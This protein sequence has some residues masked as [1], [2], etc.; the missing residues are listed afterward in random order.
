MSGK[1]IGWAMEQAT[2]SPVT[3]L[4]LLKLADN[5]NEEGVCWPSIALMVTHTELSKRAVREHL[6]RLE[7]LGL[8]RIERR[9]SCGGK[10]PNIYHLLIKPA[11]AGVVQEVHQG[12]GA[13]GAPVV[14][15]AHDLVQEV[16]RGSAGG[17]LPY[18]EEPPSEPSKNLQ[19]RAQARG[20][21]ASGDDRFKPIWQT[22]E[23]WPGFTPGM[24]HRA[25]EQ[26]WKR[27]AEARDYVG[28]AE[29]V[30]AVG[31]H[32]RW[33]ASEN[34]RRARL[35][36]PQPAHLVMHPSRWLRER[37]FDGYLRLA[38]KDAAGTDARARGEADVRESLG[39]EIF[40]RLTKAGFQ[41]QALAHW[42]HGARIEV[43][44][45]ARVVV[46]KDFTRNW[47]ETQF[48]AQLRRALGDDV[49]VE[50]ARA[51]A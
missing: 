33:L 15:V 6:E 9:T 49:R 41:A 35:R 28:D 25:A 34:D 2:G 44:P 23:R 4:V 11:G 14:H 12:G 32:G 40:A 5:A 8:V 10:L 27:L 39:E 22:F 38:E 24:S 21:E 19:H 13:G 16:H 45:P 46:P 17:A 48:A 29:L 51:A 18:K 37:C 1:V 47:I 42:F 7:A 43:G 30:A 20:G 36:P 3:K 26:A 50:V 31:A